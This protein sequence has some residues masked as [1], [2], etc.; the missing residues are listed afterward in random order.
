M[1]YLSFER[2]S[3][4]LNNASFPIWPVFFRDNE[5]AGH[6]L[7]KHGHFEAPLSLN[8]KNI[9]RKVQFDLIFRRNHE[10]F[11]WPRRRT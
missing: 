1:L 6:K 3:F 9:N 5:L 4:Y 8:S 7:E 11:G 2:E 10:G